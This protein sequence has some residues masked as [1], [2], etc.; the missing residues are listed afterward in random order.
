MHIVSFSHEDTERQRSQTFYVWSDFWLRRCV[1]FFWPLQSDD[2]LPRRKSWQRKS[3]LTPEEKED[4]DKT[5]FAVLSWSLIWAGGFLG[6]SLWLAFL[7]ACLWM[8]LFIHS[9]CFY[10]CFNLDIILLVEPAH[11]CAPGS[12]ASW[13]AGLKAS[14]QLRIEDH[15][16]VSG[17]SGLMNLCQIKNANAVFCAKHSFTQQ[18]I[19][20]AM[21][22]S[23]RLHV[24]NY[25]WLDPFH[26]FCSSWSCVW[27]SLLRHYASR[28]WAV[29]LAA[30]T[31]EAVWPA[32]N[33][34]S[35]LLPV[36]SC[37]AIRAPWS[38]FYNSRHNLFTD[39]ILDG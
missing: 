17:H 1:A 35:S 39:R 16:H 37:W 34:C 11:F 30:Q 20:T 6:M 4:F 2:P 15:S 25:N 24:S 3:S 26:L 23:A 28:L 21:H 19:I 36:H 13:I 38:H 27:C 22:T 33:C 14:V 32:C 7:D 31:A 29:C 9:V 10:L 8:H 12:L 5:R 18:R